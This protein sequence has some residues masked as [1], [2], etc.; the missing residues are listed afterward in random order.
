LYVALSSSPQKSTHRA[1][2][3]LQ[4]RILFDFCDADHSGDI[5]LDELR[6][7]VVRQ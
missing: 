6:T 7:T 2:L 5:S 3:P 1:P 4:L